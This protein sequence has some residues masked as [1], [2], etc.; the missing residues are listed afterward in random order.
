MMFSMLVCVALSE[1]LGLFGLVY[2]H[3]VLIRFDRFASVYT[4]VD[5]GDPKVLCASP[6]KKGN[7]PCGAANNHSS[8]GYR[9][10]V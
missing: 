7:G 6:E 3:Q 8:V 2:S 9:K 1:G 4:L 10:L 5:G